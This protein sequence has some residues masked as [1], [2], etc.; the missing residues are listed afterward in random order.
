MAS[1]VPLTIQCCIYNNLDG[2]V[3]IG[4]NNLYQ[5]YQAPTN[6]YWAVIV[7]RTDLSVVQNFTF[8]DNSDVPAAFNPYINNPQYMLILTTMQ[9]LSINLPTGNLYSFLTGIGAGV[10]LRRLEQIYGALNCGTWGNMGYTLV[11]VFDTTSG[12]DFS[13]YQQS[14][15]V[16]TLTLAPIQVGTSVLYTPQELR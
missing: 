15:M 6:Y 7:D 4:T 5:S 12:F 14:G 11:T 16:S 13:D 1:N 8:T 9:L 10:S 2:V 3:S